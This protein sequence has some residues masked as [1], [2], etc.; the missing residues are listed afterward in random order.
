MR[1]KKQKKY[2]VSALF[3]VTVF[4]VV[5]YATLQSYLNISGVADIS[6]TWDVS[7]QSITKA[8]T[9]GLAVET[10]T[11]SY[12]GTTAN[13]HVELRAPGDIISYKI[14]VKNNGNVPAYLHS[15]S[16]IPEVVDSGIVFT[17]VGDDG[18]L[19]VNTDPTLSTRLAPGESHIITVAAEWSEKDTTVP[20]VKTKSLSVQLNYMQNTTD[21]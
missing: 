3:F 2:L 7:I 15:V 4:T 18:P 13:F 10:V 6:T 11:P 9:S 17:V 1:S 12:N 21:S 16:G 14:V 5:G 20:T 8:Y 19:T